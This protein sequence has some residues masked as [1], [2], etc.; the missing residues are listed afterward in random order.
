[1][2]LPVLRWSDRS[3]VAILLLLF[4]AGLLRVTVPVWRSHSATVV[5]DPYTYVGYAKN[6]AKGHFTL[7]NS[8]ALL[9]GELH[10]RSDAPRT[11]GTMGPVW[12]TAIRSDGSMVYTVEA[13]YPIFLSLLIRTTGI[14][15]AIYAN[16]LLWP[17]LLL[18]VFLLVRRGVGGGVAGIAAAAAVCLLFP[19]FDHP[20]FRQMHYPWREPL[21][22]CLLVGALLGILRFT[23]TGRARWLC[24]G[25]LLL[26]LGCTV[27]IANAAYL[28]VIGLFVLL[29]PAFR[30]HPRKPLLLL[31]CAGLFLAGLMP[32][33]L[34]NYLSTGNPLKS[35]QILR[36]TREYSATEGG[37]GLSLGNVGLTTRRYL[38]EVYRHAFLLHWPAVLLAAS[39]LWTCR[40]R[41]FIWLVA[42]LLAAH[43]AL[44]LQWGNADNRHMVFATLLYSILLGAGGM[45]LVARVPA[46]T[47]VVLLAT[48]FTPLQK[49]GQTRNAD[50][51]SIGEARRLVA[52]LEKPVAENALVL[53]NRKLRD[54]V[55][56][57]GRFDVAALHE[58][59]ALQPA[60]H[61][62]A[63]VARLLSLGRSVYFLDNEDRDPK[64][65]GGDGEVIV[66]Y[67][68]A[69]EAFLREHFRLRPVLRLPAAEYGL[70]DFDSRPELT[71]YE[72]RPWDRTE[73]GFTLTSPP[74]G[75][76]FLFLNARAAG[77]NLVVTAD[78]APVDVQTHRT[79]FYHPLVLGEKTVRI[80]A[81]APHVIPDLDDVRLVGWDERIV[82]DTGY[83]AKNFDAGYFDHPFADHAEISNRRIDEGFSCTLPVRTS[84]DC[85]T[86]LGFA[87]SRISKLWH[88][89]TPLASLERP[90]YLPVRLES[91]ETRY[92]RG[93]DGAYWYALGDASAA[94]PRAGYARLTFPEF[95]GFR[96]KVERFISATAWR[97]RSLPAGDEAALLVSGHAM[98]DIDMSAEPPHESQNLGWSVK[99]AGTVVASGTCG[100]R[101]PT[102]RATACSSCWSDPPSRTGNWHMEFAGAGLA[103]IHAEPLGDALDLTWTTPANACAREGF[104]APERDE[105]SRRL[106]W[107][108]GRSVVRVP[109]Q[110]GR[111]DYRL[112]L[113]LRN[114]TPVKGRRVRLRFQGTGQS[115]EIPDGS[116]LSE[117]AFVWT[118]DVPPGPRVCADLTIE[119]DVWNPA[120]AGASTDDRD[121]GFQ[122]YS[123]KWAPQSGGG[124][125]R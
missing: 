73:A 80:H 9:A 52:A 82:V 24:A 123:L 7:Q 62:S 18:L 22:M 125:S 8:V 55:G 42:G 46:L 111:R 110:P 38:R 33:L 75:T 70:E 99:A 118:A 116:A 15:S 32:F 84:P 64:H 86:A 3:L 95:P 29:S 124:T 103:D 47:V 72:I 6:L 100:P 122:L 92:L 58:L 51:F 5:A 101:I 54:V 12:N 88:N 19:A 94:A 114:A 31:V 4:A 121:L 59:I 119:S 14:I 20:T 83:D 107:T 11:Q 43:L 39:A 10:A 90:D 69:D 105:L 66:D 98:P 85:F 49:I 109:L 27:K 120:K 17:L 77:S 37:H 71:L 56:V 79:R 108:S 57:Y 36:E 74:G 67:A 76:A 40:K 112:V 113:S 60:A 50:V 104:H 30:R 26:G 53:C 2:K 35:L 78:G 45:A 61:G 48:L 68:R 13:G 41:P 117:Q 102:S 25:A 87:V 21:F 97:R 1:M 63:Q 89:R 44:Y 23:R 96:Y 65:W 106:A 28:P 93:S 34:Q 115:F 91:G 16:F 81:A